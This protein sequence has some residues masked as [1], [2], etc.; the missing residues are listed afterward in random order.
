MAKKFTPAKVEPTESLFAGTGKVPP[1]AIDFE[2]SV[3]GALMLESDAYLQVTDILKSEYF[4]KEEHG[5]IFAAIKKRADKHNPVDINTVSEQLKIDKTLD[6]VGGLSYLVYLTNRI[7]STAHIEFHARIIAQKY[8]Q[9]ELIRIG[10]E[11]QKKGFEDVEDVSDMLNEAEQSIFELSNGN[12]KKEVQS[13]SLVANEAYAQLQEAS[14]KDGLSGVPSGFE[15]LD[16]LTLGWQNSDLVIIA[17]RPAMGKTAFVLSMAKNMA[18]G[19]NIPV[20]VF[21]LEMSSVQLVNRIIS[22]TAEIPSSVLRTGRLTQDQWDKL[23]DKMDVLRSAPMYIDDT[24]ALSISEFRSKIKRLKTLYNIKIAIIDYLQLMTAGGNQQSREQEVSTISRSLKAIAK[25]VNIPIIALS[26]LSRQV[27]QRG[28]DK[29]PQLSD[30]RESGAI[31]QDADMVIFIHR[32]EYYKLY[33]DEAGNSLIGVAE[34]IVAKHRNGAVDDVRL[35]FKSEF[36]QFCDPESLGTITTYK[37]KMNDEAQPGTDA[38]SGAGQGF[39]PNTDFDK[40]VGGP[41]QDI[42]PTDNVPF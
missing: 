2:E 29:R 31:E 28:G 23:E 21:S 4:Y 6:E 32:P 36:T 7:A 18:V 26:Q 39:T 42:T 41:N 25:E 30:L 5:K 19:N 16:K 35:Q 34:I 27:E 11:I 24:P 40:P 33:T 10:A 38:P 3:L 15:S 12:V 20:A 14:K 22:S 1:Q 9:R 37:S 17:A 8:V 13:I